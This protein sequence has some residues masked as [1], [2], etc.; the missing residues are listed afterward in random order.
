MAVRSVGSLATSV[1]VSRLPDSS[2]NFH[3]NGFDDHV[4]INNALAYANAIGAGEVLLLQGTY[5]IA[6]PITFPANN[7]VLRGVGRATFID[8]DLLSTGEH[9]IVISGRTDCTVRDLAIQTENGGGKTCYCI[10]VSDGADRFIIDNVVIVNSDFNAISISG[11]TI[12]TGHINKC[13]ILASDVTGIDVD[14]GGTHYM[15]NLLITDCDIGNCRSGIG[16][17]PSSGNRYCLIH[18]NVIYDCG[19]RG[20]YATDFVYSKIEGNTVYSNGWSGIHVYGTTSAL[21]SDNISYDNVRYGIF[22]EDVD[23]CNVEENI[24]NENDSGDIGTYDGIYV[25]GDSDD[26]LILGNKC[27]DNDRYGIN[28]V[29]TRNRVKENDFSGNTAGAFNDGGTDTRTPFLFKEVTDADGNVGDHPVLVLPDTVDTTFRFQVMIPLEFQEL[30]T[31]QAIVLQTATGGPPDMQWSTTTDWGKLC[32]GENY[33]AG[34]DAE[35]DQTTAVAQNNLVCIDVSASLTGIAA[36]D[37][38]GFTF[39]RRGTQGGDTIDAD[40]YYLGFRLRYV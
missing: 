30:V 5:S 11:T 39:I 31:A 4:D 40:A 13:K 27:N 15:Y 10:A 3:C 28:V 8:G 26:N 24:C 22:L 14:M 18:G 35:T 21:I 38:V 37:L 25:D 33:N 20:I 32:A 34:T 16:F 7:L 29:G 9:A 1:T 19:Q 23:Y 17:N 6:N 12:M 2:G 36:G